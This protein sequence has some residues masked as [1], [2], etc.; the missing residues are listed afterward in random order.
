MSISEGR[1]SWALIWGNG[2]IEVPVAMVP[3]GAVVLSLY[4]FGSRFP[5]LL[6][7]VLGLVLVY[8]SVCVSWWWLKGIRKEPYHN[9]FMLVLFLT[10]SFVCGCICWNALFPC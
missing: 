8:L 4:G 10:I 2:A 7:A 9:V 5:K 1:L 6:L 3:Y